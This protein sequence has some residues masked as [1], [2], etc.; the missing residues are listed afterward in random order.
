MLFLERCSRAAACGQGGVIFRWCFKS[1][2]PRH[3]V[4]LAGKSKTMS[5]SLYVN[6][7]VFVQ[8]SINHVQSSINP[9]D[10]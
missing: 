9:V 4:E 10:F 7:Q 6:L 1:L 2:Q 3:V 8:S 5:A